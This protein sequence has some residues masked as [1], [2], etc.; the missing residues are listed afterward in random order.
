MIAKEKAS[1][2][3]NVGGLK[4]GV[5][6]SRMDTVKYSSNLRNRNNSIRNG[7]YARGADGRVY[8]LRQPGPL[9]PHSARQARVVGA[10]HRIADRPAQECLNTWT[11]L[12]EAA[13]GVIKGVDRTP[14]DGANG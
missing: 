6:A 11:P 14:E 3:G 13:M 2:G 4:A 5:F 9:S 1:D 12:G 8:F 7:D 10:L